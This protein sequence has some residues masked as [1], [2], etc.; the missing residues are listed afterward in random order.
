MDT[1][2]VKM[3]LLIA[4]HIMNKHLKDDSHICGYLGVVGCT[5]SIIKR[6]GFG[7]NTIYG[8]E[9]DYMYFYNFFNESK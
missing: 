6:S 2:I 4:L 8:A 3:R 1:S 7:I 5:I 9:S